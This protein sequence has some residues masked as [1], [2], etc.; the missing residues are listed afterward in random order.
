ML[1]SPVRDSK[2][3]GA[4]ERAVRLWSG[5]LRIIRHHLERRI[6]TT[7]PKDSALMSWLVSWAADVMFRYEVHS[8]GRTNHEW[9]AGHRCDQPVAGSAEKMHVKFTTDKNHRN[10][11]NPEWC[12]S[13]FVGVTGKT[14]GYL[15]ATNDGVFSCATIRRLHDEEAYDPECVQAVKIT[16]R[17]YVPEGAKSFPIGVRS[18]LEKQTSRMQRRIQ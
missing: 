2:A 12:T 16:Y 14:T 5:Q 10:K 9:I 4:A 6:K 18:V 15:V 7:I 1:E 13:F 3:H 8:T 11:M 17:E